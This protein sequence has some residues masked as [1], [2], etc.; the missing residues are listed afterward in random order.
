MTGKLWVLD[1]KSMKSNPDWA[2]ARK[3]LKYIP[4]LNPYKLQYSLR[5]REKVEYCYNSW[6]LKTKML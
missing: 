6:I 3:V 4:I 5:V 2:T 1:R